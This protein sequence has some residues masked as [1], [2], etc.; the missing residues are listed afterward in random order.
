M[1]KRTIPTSTIERAR[2]LWESGKSAEDVA[3]ALKVGRNSVIGM[4][5]RYGFTKRETPI[6]PM[7]GER[8]DAILHIADSKPWFGYRRIASEVGVHMSTVVAVLG[9]HRPGRQ[10][11]VEPRATPERPAAAPPRKARQNEARARPEPRVHQPRRDDPAPASGAGEKSETT[12]RIP[13]AASPRVPL[14]PL[15]TWITGRTKPGCSWPI[16]E[17]GTEDFRYCDAPRAVRCYCAEHA[18]VAYRPP[19]PNERRDVR[20]RRV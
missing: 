20:M 7:A 16:G 10:K 1:S 18:A 8:L 5:H 9:R 3:A 2:E 12:G 13:D 17:P 6:K 15:P 14:A 19:T 11:V 4:A